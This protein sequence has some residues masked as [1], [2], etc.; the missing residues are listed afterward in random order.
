MQKLKTLMKRL[1]A[2]ISAVLLTGMLVCSGSVPSYAAGNLD[3]STDYPGITVKAG[4]MV[5]FGLDFSSSSS[6]DAS[7][8]VESIPKGWS[9]YFRGSESQISK[10]HVNAGSDAA[11][12]SLAT[13]SLTLPDDVK[14][15][16]YIVRLK[17]DAG[18]GNSDMLELEITVNQEETGQSNFTAEYPE[19]QGSSGTSFSFDTTLVNNRGTEQSYSLSAETPSGW[20][21][22][23]T[24]SSESS[25]VASITVEG[26]SSQGL[27]VDIT[28]PETIEEGEYTIPCTAVSANET[29]KLE[30][31]VKITGKYD[32][33]ISTESGNLNVDAYANSKKKVTLT[34]K[35]TGNVELKDLE[36]SSS[37][38]S[39]WEVEFEE[40][41]IETLEAGDSKEVTAYITPDKDAMTGDYMTTI[42]IKNDEISSE[43]ELRISVKTRTA[44]GFAA[45]G[46]IAVL[47]CGLSFL[48]K[49]YGRR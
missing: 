48:F 1:G 19:Q 32:G 4:E 11:E 24:P 28:P 10:V 5:N 36:L 23:F 44:W 46:I 21:V 42:T 34:V 45:V 30:L 26:G 40:D 37:A 43:V 6:C 2:C 9:G 15:G 8:S 39:N 13:F 18:N 16:N 47:L 41:T 38:P 27:T 35:N 7:L 20:E 29:L 49:K 14:E 12:S 31:K 33:E 25:Q 3:M 17:A 22:G